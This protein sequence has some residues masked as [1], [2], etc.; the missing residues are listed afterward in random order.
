VSNI[1]ALNSSMHSIALA[2][3]NLSSH[4]YFHSGIFLIFILLITS[5]RTDPAYPIIKDS[6]LKVEIVAEGI[7]FPTSMAFLDKDHI[8]VLEKNTGIV[9]MVTDESPTRAFA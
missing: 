1:L 5:G 8:L 7:K 9:R 3:A 4:S 6:N 2:L